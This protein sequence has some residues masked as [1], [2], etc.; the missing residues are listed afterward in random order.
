M[1]IYVIK[2]FVRNVINSICRYIKKIFRSGTSILKFI[3]IVYLILI[4][5]AMFRGVL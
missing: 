5:I 3:L 2:C 1:K 4:F